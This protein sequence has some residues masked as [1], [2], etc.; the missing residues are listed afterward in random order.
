M[1]YALFLDCFLKAE[2]QIKRPELFFWSKSFS[3]FNCAGRHH[4]RRWRKT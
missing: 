2:V 3:K 4:T 1:D